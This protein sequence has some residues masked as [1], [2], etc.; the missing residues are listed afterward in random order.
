M[1]VHYVI[2]IVHLM[3][4]DWRSKVDFTWVTVWVILVRVGIIVDPR[5]KRAGV[6]HTCRISSAEPSSCAALASIIG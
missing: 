6:V 3:R 4:E 1:P 2:Y 5:R